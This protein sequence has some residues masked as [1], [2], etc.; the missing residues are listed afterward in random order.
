MVPLRKFEN[1]NWAKTKDRF[2]KNSP[3]LSL[4]IKQKQHAFFDLQNRYLRKNGVMAH[5]LRKDGKWTVVKGFAPDTTATPLA[6][7]HGRKPPFIAKPIVRA[8]L[9]A[10]LQFKPQELFSLAGR[11]LTRT[12]EQ[13]VKVAFRS[14]PN[15][16]GWPP[17]AIADWVSWGHKL[18]IKFFKKWPELAPA[19]FSLG[20]PSL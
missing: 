17:E 1:G 19:G 13:N 12:Q 20:G 16:S 11:E 14:N 4:F 18:T 15:T 2:P 3:A 6:V 8:S 5:I 7:M 9:P 10:S